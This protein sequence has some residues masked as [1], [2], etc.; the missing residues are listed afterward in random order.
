MK[1]LLK[2]RPVRI[3]LFVLLLS[4][5]SALSKAEGDVVCSAGFGSFDADATTHVALS[6]GPPKQQTG[7]A[8]RA[9]QAKLRWDKQELVIAPAARQVDVDLMGGELESKTPVAALQIKQT[10]ADPLMRYEIYS[11]AKPPQKLRTIS[12]GDYFRAADTNLD[13]QIEIWTHDAGTINGF[14]GIP[15]SAFDSPPSIALR[16]EKQRL[17]D[18]SAEFPSRFDSQI[19]TLRAQ[20]DPSDL[21]KFKNSDGELSSAA[22]LSG[23]ALL[24]LMSTK[25]KALE[26][27]WSYLYSGREREAWQA[28]A[29]LWPASDLDRIRSA[30]L[31]A[32]AG[33]IRSDVDG[34]SCGPPARRKKRVA[35]YDSA[36]EIVT[37][38]TLIHGGARGGN[39]RVTSTIAGGVNR[40]VVGS[41][42]VAENQGDQNQMTIW[43]ADTQPQAIFFRRPPPPDNVPAADLNKEIVVDMVIDSAGKVWSIETV[44]ETDKD[45]IRA[46]AKWKFVPALK[47]GRPVA[48]RLR[49]GITP[50]Q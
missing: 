40:S 19:A 2:G 23:N 41:A 10:D 39:E 22:D 8:N 14:E 9:C 24:G 42:S 18:V 3:F 12:G 4:A 30:I 15:L 37:V 11:L 6:V 47:L 1:R 38:S 45:L 48:S 17:M 44:G 25:I 49:L 43:K 20:L 7:F 34:V 5:L 21:N 29:D 28:L 32:R 36:T 13:G 35:I 26:I 46:S 33:G 50:F 27:V 16:F 31:D